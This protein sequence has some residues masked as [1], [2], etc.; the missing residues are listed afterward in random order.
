L[1]EGETKSLSSASAHITS[2]FFI[3][4]ARYRDLHAAWVDL[5]ARLAGRFSLPVAM[6][7][8]QQRGDADLLIRCMEDEF[9]PETAK[10]ASNVGLTEFS[11]HYQK[12]LSEAWII[13]CYEI[14]RA[15][16]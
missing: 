13:G 15:C 16:D 6:M 3:A 9:D 14:F 2:A 8:L 4:R 1:T 11:Y 7:S 10:S 5:S 12:M